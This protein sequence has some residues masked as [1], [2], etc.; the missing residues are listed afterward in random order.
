MERNKLLVFLV[1]IICFF[2]AGAL[3]AQEAGFYIDY[4]GDKPRIIQKLVWE[5]EEYAM[6]YEVDIQLYR[7]GPPSGFYEYEKKTTAGF[8]LDIILHPGKYRYNVTPYDYLGRSGESSEWIEFEIF[9][10][11]HPV[12]EEFSPGAF[13]LDKHKKRE[14]T[15]SGINLYDES[16]IY[17]RN[18]SHDFFPVDMNFIDDNKVL[19]YFDD[20][21]LSSGTYEIYAVNPGGLESVTGEFIIRYR[22]P[23]DIFLKAAYTPVIPIY[24]ELNELFSDGFYLAGV[25]LG[26]EF[27]SSKR[28][29]V[30]TG[31]EISYTGYLLNSA[32][33]FK[34]KLSEVLEGIFNS[35]DGMAIHDIDVNLSIQKRFFKRRMAATLRLGCG[36]SIINGAEIYN[37]KNFSVHLNI[38]LSYMALLFDIFHLEIGADFDHHFSGES[39]GIIKPKLALVWKF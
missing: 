29:V 16:N 6:Q 32:V 1:T 27:I 24:G 4:S 8:F 34:S 19:L 12:I 26:L 33:S 30:N 38:G 37:Q 14:L 28:A 36:F 23:L 2:S 21:K 15:I 9:T 31:F 7:E 10:A 11:Y 20:E 22:K 39:S 18:Q 35:S 13:Y 5:K 25:T 3:R 17:L